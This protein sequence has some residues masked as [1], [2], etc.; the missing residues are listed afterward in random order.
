MIVENTFK[1][2]AFNTDWD[3]WNGWNISIFQ[4]K[5][6]ASLLLPADLLTLEIIANLKNLPVCGQC[7]F[8]GDAIHRDKTRYLDIS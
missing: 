1:L 4:D 7:N 2:D 3:G 6:L 5:V 8:R